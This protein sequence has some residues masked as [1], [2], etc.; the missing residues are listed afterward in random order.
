MPSNGH[1]LLFQK[2][3]G[4]FWLSVWA[5]PSIWNYTS[6]AE[7]TPPTE[8]VTVSLPRA[9]STVSVYDP[10]SGTASISSAS[11]VSSVNLSVTDHPL[12]VR[13]IQ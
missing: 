1:S 7:I 2:S 12:L 13:L 8:A 6:M 9:F 5:E 3:N 4:E 11:G 10:I